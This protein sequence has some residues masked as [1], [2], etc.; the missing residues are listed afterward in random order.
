MAAGV[1]RLNDHYIRR[2]IFSI[3][4]LLL[5]V[6]VLL[7][8]N[9][10]RLTPQAQLSGFALLG[11][12]LIF[13]REVQPDAPRLGRVLDGVLALLA[14][15]ACGFVLVQSQPW[16]SRWWLA[17]QSLGERAGAEQPLDTLVGIVGLVVVLEAARRTVGWTLPILAGVFLL[18]AKLGPWLPD[19]LMPHRGYGLDRIVAQ[20]FLHSQG[21]FGIALKVMFSYVFLFVVFGALLEV[22][23]ATQYVIEMARRLFRGASGGPAKVAVMS[24]GL[25]GSLSGSA[26]A[27]TATTGTFT[28][29][30][31]K[32]S[33]FPSHQA[34][35]LEAAASSGGALV[36]PVMG[37]GAYM[38]LEI[39]DPPVSYLEIIRATLIP[40][41][42]YY[43]SIFLIVHLRTRS[44]AP[45]E[46]DEETAA[47]SAMRWEGVVF[48]SGLAGLILFLLSGFSVFRAVSL[49]ML[50]VLLIS[51][52][53]QRTRLGW[54]R[55]K[56][57]LISASR[58]G[59]SLISAASCVG[60][61]IGV[62][63]LTGIGA[64][65]PA[66][67][68]PLAQQN[69]ILALMAL[70][71]SSL[72]LGMGLPSAVCYLLLATMVG[73]VL[74]QLGVAAL[75]AH[76]FIFYFGL[77]SMV[78]PPVAL[79]AYAASSI[80]GSGFL[81]SSLAAFRFS[82]MGFIL[83]YLFI[84]R[85]ALL[86]LDGQG[87]AAAPIGVAMAVSICVVGLLPMA[88]ALA[89]TFRGPLSKSTR[90]AL[91]SAAL[92]VLFPGPEAWDLLAGLNVTNLVGALSVG[93]MLLS[94]RKAVSP[95]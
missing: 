54:Q 61:I 40:A 2:S 13:L 37:A 85:P 59:V 10:P 89:G 52:F 26:V 16:F 6:Y 29:P 76:L 71:I 69:L 7:E 8:V 1:Q 24:S 91:G 49:A 65:L 67:I 35:G 88:A 3:G 19:W 56:A 17:G 28:I 11:L 68:L 20:T 31:M 43:L 53:N 64:R 63:T 9:Y 81:Q 21:V 34:A 39:I 33:G 23:G 4:A 57:S 42:L 77:M 18:Y 92:L 62:V 44:F 15:A 86:M 46:L 41:I 87:Q 27:N 74:G 14:V 84:Y 94:R 90:F 12:L 58:A 51:S 78:T 22:T 72:I 73:S 50:V 60:V 55:V 82:L 47:S 93:A 79:A 83:P 75:A 30:M 48:V 45:A 95:V 36:P 38:M 70:M 32:S 66:L 5:P 80:A 25:M